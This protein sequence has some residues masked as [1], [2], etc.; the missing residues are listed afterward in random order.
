ML[1]DPGVTDGNRKTAGGGSEGFGGAAGRDSASFSPRG[2]M[3]R[4][5]WLLM[6]FAVRPK[7]KAI[8]QHDAHHGG[9]IMYD[10]ACGKR[11]SKR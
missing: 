11:A 4:I 7:T 10:C 2:A 1:H 8:R 6:E 3:Q 9:D 5:D